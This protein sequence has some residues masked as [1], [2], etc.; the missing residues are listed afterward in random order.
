MTST[1]QT[2]GNIVLGLHGNINAIDRDTAAKDKNISVLVHHN[3]IKA[4]GQDNNK[5]KCGLGHHNNLSTIDQDTAENESTTGL[6]HHIHINAIEWD[7]AKN[8]AQ[9]VWDT[10]TI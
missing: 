2:N 10:T 7:A 9:I 8:K 1:P 6:G 4:I 5:G 3:N